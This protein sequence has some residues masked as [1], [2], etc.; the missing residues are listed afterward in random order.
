VKGRR[1]RLMALV[2]ESRT[3][4]L[5]EAPHR[6]IKTLSAMCTQGFGER[7]IS[8]AREL[9]KRY[10]TIL[11]IT[12]S[13]AVQYYAE[14]EPKGE[15]VLI[16][17]GLD[18]YSQ[19]C[20]NTHLVAVEASQSNDELLLSLLNQGLSVREA[21]KEAARRTGQKRNMLYELALKMKNESKS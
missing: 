14:H 18:E 11:R 12:V 17:E 1:L 8:I 6:L 16:I 19:R 20:P 5:Y 2:S 3:I 10:E 21:A 15:Y 13:E 4:I 7:R 9:T